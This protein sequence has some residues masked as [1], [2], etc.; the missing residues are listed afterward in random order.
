MSHSTPLKSAVVP[1]MLLDS[2]NRQEAMKVVD[3]RE[4]LVDTQGRLH[5]E[6][7]TFDGEVIEARN[8]GSEGRSLQQ[9]PKRM[10]DERW[11]L[12]S[13]TSLMPPSAKVRGTFS[14]VRGAASD[15]L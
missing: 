10:E 1:V 15:W 9:R 8:R 7:R 12:L 13:S 3:P 4:V 6:V 5:Q 2:L 11:G 14:C